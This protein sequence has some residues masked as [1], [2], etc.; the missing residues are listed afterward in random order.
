MPCLG[1]WVPMAAAVLVKGPIA[2][3]L[4]VTTV[5]S[6]CAWHR[7][8]SWLRFLRIGRGVVILALITLP[9]AILVT[10]ATDGA[11]LDIAVRGDFVAKVKSV[12]ESHGAPVG[13]YAMLAVLLLWPASLLLPRAASQLPLLSSHVE[14]RF[15]LAWIL[16]FWL[17]IEFVPTKLPHYPLPVI[18]ALAVLLVCAV[19]APLPGATSGKF[20]PVIRRWIARMSRICHAGGW[21]SAGNLHDLGGTH[22]WWCD[23]WP[24]FCLFPFGSGDGRS[25]NLAGV[26]MASQRRDPHLWRL[27][28]PP[29]PC[30]ISLSSQA[31]CHPCR[32]FTCPVPF[33]R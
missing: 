12:Q 19:E 7:D 8:V 17:V 31:C 2:P 15:L 26:H 14:S 27:F 30:S 1:I 9:W 13:A 18:P 21:W 10:L 6:L 4:A 5:A 24:C 29:E 28:L 25:G 3:L 22:L 16:P 32:A 33:T 20:R 23:C 11:F